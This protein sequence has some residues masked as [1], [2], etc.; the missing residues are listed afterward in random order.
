MHNE[1]KIIKRFIKGDD[2]AFDEI[3]FK[4]SKKLYY[5]G[6]GLLKDPEYSREMVQDV[7]VTLWEKRE[8]VNPDLNFENYLLTIAYNSIRKFFRKRSI[9]HKVKNYLLK[10]SPELVENTDDSLIYEELYALASESIDKMPQKRKTVY[11][12]SRQEG[13]SIR[14][15]A[16]KLSISTRTAENHL[17][18]ALKYLKKEMAKLSLPVKRN[19]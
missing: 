7:F 13:M 5:F 17:A 4:Y 12:L 3:Y 18:Q 15:I 19:S 1:K 14:E 6:L 8:N 16:G 2:V 11:K 10:N 9:E